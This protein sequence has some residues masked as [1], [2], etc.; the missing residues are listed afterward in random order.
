MPTV[1]RFLYSSGIFCRI[2]RDKTAPPD[3]HYQLQHAVLQRHLTSARGVQCEQGILLE[4]PQGGP[5]VC[6]YYCSRWSCG[7]SERATRDRGFDV[8][9]AVG[10]YPLSIT[11]V[12]CTEVYALVI[13]ARIHQVGYPAWVCVF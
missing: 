5:G 10:R 2:P 4:Y 6:N 7:E 11:E 13:Q 12:S 3:A 1:S 9:E 8:T